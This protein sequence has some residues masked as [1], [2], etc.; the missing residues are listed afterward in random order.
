MLTEGASAARLSVASTETHASGERGR[1]IPDPT[2]SELPWYR[3]WVLQQLGNQPQRLLLCLPDFE[4]PDDDSDFAAFFFVWDQIRELALAQGPKKVSSI[5]DSLVRLGVIFV[6]LDCEARQAAKDLVFAVL[7]WQTMLYKP[8]FT[9]HFAGKYA[10]VDELHGH[11]GDARLALSQQVGSCNKNLSD[12][13]LGFGMM[14]P[15]RN[16]CAFRDAEDQARFRQTG[17]V[18]SGEVN[19]HVLTKLCGVSIHWVDSISCHFELDTYSGRLFLYRYPSFCVSCLQQHEARTNGHGQSKSVLHRCALERSG[20]P[21]A[22][23]EDVT[24]LLRLH[25]YAS[26]KKPRSILQLWRDRRDSTAWL[27]LWSVLVFGTI[28]VM[29]ALLQAVFQILQY[30]EARQGGGR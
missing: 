26:S 12:F 13:L 6:K 27:A 21:W 9:S 1:R 24:S 30:V 3:W 5:T 23:E 19:A 28:S 17:A 25:S 14:L 2:F 29:L 15:P 20:P 8:E 16:Y 11:H 10:I 4:S 22:T 18:S 7:G